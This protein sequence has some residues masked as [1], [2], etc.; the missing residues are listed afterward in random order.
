MGKNPKQKRHFITEFEAALTGQPIERRGAK[1]F[2]FSHHFSTTN[3][4]NVL[5][6][7]VLNVRICCFSSVLGPP[8][9]PEPLQICGRGGG[10]GFQT[11]FSA[12]DRCSVST[13]SILVAR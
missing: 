12:S 13:P 11:L 10:P 3:V 4:K 7:A 9:S 1:I 6:A 8:S 5:L 2:L